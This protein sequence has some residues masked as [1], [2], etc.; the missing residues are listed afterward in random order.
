MHPSQLLVFS[1]I[2]KLLSRNIFNN[3]REKHGNETARQCRQLEKSITKKSKVKLD[4]DFLLTCK[5]ENLIPSFAKP[6]LSI[7][8]DGRLRSKIGKLVIETE[9]K[10]KHVKNRQ[11]RRDIEEETADVQTKLGFITFYAFKYRISNA[12]SQK[13]KK[14]MVTHKKKLQRLRSEQLPNNLS[15][16][17]RKKKKIL[18]PVI[19]NFSQYDLAEEEI[20]VLSKTLDHYIPPTNGRSKRVQ[21][22]FERLYSNILENAKE[23]DAAT[24]LTLKTNFLNTF[25]GYKNVKI[26]SNDQ[27]IN[28]K[29]GFQP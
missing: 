8:V 27:N 12:V 25:N 5:K 18:P 11:L 24:K 15:R 6:K 4:L 14:W 28:N 21:V 7:P 23:L 29:R 9:L 20:R 17:E 13:K 1:F 22:E 16:E 26:T 2:F 3:I 19:H 10:N